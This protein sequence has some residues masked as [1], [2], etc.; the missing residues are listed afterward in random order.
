MH[1]QYVVEVAVSRY[2]EASPGQSRAALHYST[3]IHFPLMWSME[4]RKEFKKAL[5]FAKMSNNTALLGISEP[6][7]RS[8]TLL[9][10]TVTL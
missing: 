6:M 9:T 7:V 8:Y 4:Y 5:I 2:P 1:V 3:C 10:L